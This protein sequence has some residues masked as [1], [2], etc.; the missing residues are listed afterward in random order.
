M[1]TLPHLNRRWMHRSGQAMTE[2]TIGLVA[3]VVIVATLFQIA[4]MA[5]KHTDALMDARTEAD[6]AAFASSSI[7]SPE[8]I[9]SIEDGPDG[10]SYSRDDEVTTSTEGGFLSNVVDYGDPDGLSTYVPNNGI[11]LLR[12]SP[13]PSA[14]FGL[15][16]GYES[17]EVD[18][19]PAVQHL[20]YDSPTLDVEAEVW[21]VWTTG[22]Y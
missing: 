9:G 11:S 2:F 10:R 7:D 8:F 4:L 14:S 19:L 6:E 20:L 3:T 15:V 16:R 1:T 5:D 13:I 22:Y 21:M 12:S 18:L 17:D